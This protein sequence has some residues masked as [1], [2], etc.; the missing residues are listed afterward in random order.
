MY[1][2]RGSR[3]VIGVQHPLGRHKPD[4]ASPLT[5]RKDRLQARSHVTICSLFMRPDG[6][7]PSMVLFILMVHRN[8]PSRGTIAAC[9]TAA[10]GP[11]FDCFPYSY[12]LPRN[13]ANVG[14][15][16]LRTGQSHGKNREVWMAWRASLPAAVL[17]VRRMGMRCG[18]IAADRDC[19]HAT[20]PLP[21][22]AL[23]P[24]FAFFALSRDHPSRA[25]E[26]RGSAGMV[27][28]ALPPSLSLRFRSGL[29]L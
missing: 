21:H 5:K 23:A 27:P 8:W 29:T 14:T 2:Y 4:R 20:A 7:A 10:L 15:I 17:D 12:G 19:C 16:A 28:A 13:W 11:R 3:A 1:H 6:A 25:A 18:R 22:G 9:L 24:S 26:E